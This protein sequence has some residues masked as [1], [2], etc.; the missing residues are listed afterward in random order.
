MQYSILIVDDN[1]ADRYLLKRMILGTQLDVHFFEKSNGLEALNFLQDYQRNK[2]E[3]PQVYPPMLCFL[4]IN[5]PIMGGW[6]F[7]SEFTKVRE[8]VPLQSLAIM[9]FSSS[10]D[11]SEQSRI[12]GVEFVAGYIVKG[13]T[14]TSEL[15]DVIV[16]L[17]SVSE[18]Q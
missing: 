5:M 14:S 4:D 7:V 13:E 3:N 15:K 1:E 2:E 11:A 6:E 17:C 9:M 16:S 10:S 12:E 18:S 8:S